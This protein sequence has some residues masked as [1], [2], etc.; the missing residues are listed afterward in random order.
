[1]T[2]DLKVTSV[3]PLR[4]NFDHIAARIGPDKPATRYQEAVWG[5]Q[6]ELNFHY[7]PTWD[8]AR[9]LYGRRRTALVV[10]DFDDFVD[11]RQYYYGSWTMQ[12]GRQQ[13]SQEKNFDFVEKRN[14]LGALPIALQN[15]IADLVIPVRHLAWA[16]NTNNSYIA[17]YGFG[18]PLT[19]AASMHMIDHLG[20]AQ[21][22]SRIGL[23]LADNETTVLDAA[24][25]AWLTSAEWQP[26]RA[27]TETSM[28]THD[29]FELFVLQN[30]LIDG[31]IHPL[32][33]QHFDARVVAAGG[34]A[35]SMLCEFMSEWYTESCRWVD[36]TLKIAA[37][38]STSNQNLLNTW[39]AQWSPRLRE[40]L[41]PLAGKAFA[42]DAPGIVDQ[43]FTKLRTRAAAVGLSF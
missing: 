9:E 11:P 13:D 7:R 42:N 2:I 43:L 18:A 38:E 12:R 8:A 1:M 32:V 35:F 16:A 4:R 17:A 24:K 31:A 30:F 21:Y 41:L 23:L 26:L 22:I 3:E 27:R 20:I 33:F 39:L 6:P 10:K 29:W 19:S 37:E 36:A 40:T 14:L 5:L 15:S 28:C 25:C 34:A